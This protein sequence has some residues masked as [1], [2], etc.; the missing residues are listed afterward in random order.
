MVPRV[1]IEP[2][3]PSSSGLRSTTELPRHTEMSTWKGFQTICIVQAIAPFVN[4][5]HAN[6]ENF[7]QIHA[8]TGQN[9]NFMPP[10]LPIFCYTKYLITSTT[11][12]CPVNA[13]AVPAHHKQQW[14]L[15]YFL[16]SPKTTSWYQKMS[17]SSF[18]T[19]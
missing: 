6:K 5:I 3:T 17:C 16:L 19:L 8:Q 9:A 13:F 1:G 4:G 11:E 15:A 14:D 2:T 12:P 18:L 10:L 7:F